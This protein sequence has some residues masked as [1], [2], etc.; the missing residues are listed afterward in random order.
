MH[1]YPFY[2]E[3]G[4]S[5]YGPLG[6]VPTALFTS[7]L[8]TI[9]LQRGKLFQKHI[10]SGNGVRS[11]TGH[12]LSISPRLWNLSEIHFYQIGDLIIVK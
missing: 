12:F 1:G 8:R 5:S 6:S 9:P 4:N 10:F 3:R 11:Y 7:R 2:E